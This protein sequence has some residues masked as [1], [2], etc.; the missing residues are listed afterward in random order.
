YHEIW[1]AFTVLA[2]LAHFVAVGSMTLS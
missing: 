1:H 2:A